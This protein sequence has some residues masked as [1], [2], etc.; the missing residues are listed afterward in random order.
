M[1]SHILP[2]D[3]PNFSQLS[4]QISVHAAT[5][6]APHSSR[7]SLTAF[8]HWRWQSSTSSSHN[9]VHCSSRLLIAKPPP[10]LHLY[11]SRKDALS[12]KPRLSSNLTV[13]VEISLSTSRRNSASSLYNSIIASLKTRLPSRLRFKAKKE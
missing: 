5:S 8:S 9:E 4:S 13:S 1:L 7:Q 6:K 2:H 12:L 10:H 11:L 3:S